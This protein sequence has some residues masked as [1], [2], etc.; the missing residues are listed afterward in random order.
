[1]IYNSYDIFPKLMF[2]VVPKK[3]FKNQQDLRNI[4][5]NY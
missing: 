5:R 1:M 4:K 3:Y 2:G